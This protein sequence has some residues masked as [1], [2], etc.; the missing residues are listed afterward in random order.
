MFVKFRY[1]FFF[2]PL[3]VQRTKY[4][5]STLACDACARSVNKIILKT[6]R[7][8]TLVGQCWSSSP[9]CA[10]QGRATRAVVLGVVHHFEG[11]LT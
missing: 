10:K 6:R 4:N 11:A 5:C 3:N 2:L 8:C 7:N 9:V 1:V